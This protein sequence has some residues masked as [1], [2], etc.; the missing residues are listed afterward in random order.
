MSVDIKKWI[1]QKCRNFEYAFAQNDVEGLVD[2]Y[3]NEN[4]LVIG[5]GVGEF[6]GREGAI[7]Y[8]SG[9]IKQFRAASFTTTNIT[10]T[11][12]GYTETG[13]VE[14]S[15]RDQEPAHVVLEYVVTWRLNNMGEWRVALDY[16]TP[17]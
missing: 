4:P 10:S 8:F 17:G 14:L 9:A 5:D 1:S 15:P 12:N 7:Q 3:Y 13:F 2:D 6:R 16:F 11:A